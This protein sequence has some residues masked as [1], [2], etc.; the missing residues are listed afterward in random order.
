[1]YSI[2]LSFTRKTCMDSPNHTEPTDREE[3]LVVVTSHFGPQTQDSRVLK[4]RKG[5]ER[6]DR[7]NTLLPG[8]KPVP[9]KLPLISLIGVLQ[10]RPL[11][12]SV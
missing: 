1:M 2:D 7:P 8:R 12:N 5:L 6:T 3:L 9:N 4:S 11:G 10:L